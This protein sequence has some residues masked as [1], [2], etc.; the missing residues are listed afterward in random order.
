[1]KQTM[2]VIDSSNDYNNINQTFGYAKYC[3]NRYPN[4]ALTY[5]ISN[6]PT[7]SGVSVKIFFYQE[8]DLTIS[9]TFLY[10]I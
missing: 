4:Q 9:Y 6:Y 7:D 10:S 3:Y 2:Q 5:F 8:F 1:M